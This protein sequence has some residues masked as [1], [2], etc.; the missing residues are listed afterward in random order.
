M[1]GRTFKLVGRFDPRRCETSDVD[2][3]LNVK[4]VGLL[5]NT[6]LKPA[7]NFRHSYQVDIR[8]KEISRF[9]RSFEGALAIK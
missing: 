9:K 4:Q 7:T 6:S 8:G 5:S 3:V 1:L 2:N